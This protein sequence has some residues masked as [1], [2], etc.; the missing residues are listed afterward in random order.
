MFAV[1]YFTAIVGGDVAYVD[2]KLT[3][4]LEATLFQLMRVR[5]DNA[6]AGTDSARTNSTVG[7]HA[8]YFIIPMLSLGGELRYQRWLSTP[9]TLDDGQQG[10]LHRTPRWTR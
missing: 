7:L 3:V 2:H 8:G 9:T 10:Q 1:N 5:G 4:Q 6:A